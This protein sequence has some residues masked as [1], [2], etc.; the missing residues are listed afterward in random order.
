M[1][2]PANGIL[3]VKN[4]D[5]PKS[6]NK[7]K[8]DYDYYLKEKDTR[9]EKQK[10]AYNRQQAFIKKTEEFIEK[11]I[12]RASTTKQA[13]SRR[14]MLEKLDIIE[15]PTTEYKPHI[16]FPFSKELSQ[17]VLKIKE[18]EIGYDKPLLPK[19]S[20]IIRKNERIEIYGKNGIGKT[21]FVKTIL[22]E[23]EPLSG[24][25]TFAPSVD[26]NYLSQEEELNLEMT[27][28]DYIRELYPL[29]ET[30]KVLSTLAPLGIKGDLSRKPLYELSG[31]EL[32]RVRIARLTLK[33]SNFLI[34]DE[35]TNHLDKITKDELK[36]AISEFNGAVLLISHEKGFLDDI[37][38]QVIKF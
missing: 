35:P 6:I 16:N 25:F 31:G 21:T 24:S 23:I 27:P 29:M 28:V 4:T 30:G 18:L 2:K 34:L 9:L 17:E 12:V 8:G 22:K 11:N 5:N 13:Q 15:K 10:E 14:K 7:Y 20:R 1:T 32:E 36:R 38:D 3:I 37:V 26:I 33:K 19:I